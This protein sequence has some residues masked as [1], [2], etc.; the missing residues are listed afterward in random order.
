MPFILPPSAF[1]LAFPSSGLFDFLQV[2]VKFARI[3]CPKKPD[4]ILRSCSN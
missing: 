3:I 4:S 2:V 1:I